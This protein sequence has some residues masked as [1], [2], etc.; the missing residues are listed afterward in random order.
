MENINLYSLE[1]VLSGDFNAPQGML[2][3]LI[4]VDG[5]EEDI[6]S[7]QHDVEL[8]SQIRLTYALPFRPADDVQAA[9][10]GE[11]VSSEITNGDLRQAMREV[12]SWLTNDVEGYQFTPTGCSGDIWDGP[13]QTVMQG[14]SAFVQL[15]KKEC[16]E[17]DWATEG[18]IRF[19]ILVATFG[20]DEALALTGGGHAA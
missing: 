15:V 14:W 16:G 11:Q 3:Q 9:L 13:Q 10:G 1:Q 20:M 7:V 17:G 4:N 19:T 6:R 18:V 2:P 12:A 8:T 5:T